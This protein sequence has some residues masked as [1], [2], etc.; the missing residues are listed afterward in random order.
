MNSKTRFNL[1][2]HPSHSVPHIQKALSTQGMHNKVSKHSYDSSQIEN[3]YYGR[4]IIRICYL[5]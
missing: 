4:L 5:S 1:A 2:F 3:I